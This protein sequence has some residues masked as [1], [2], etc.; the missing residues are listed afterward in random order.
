M[1]TPTSATRL[2][3]VMWST[4]GMLC[5]SR[6][7]GSKASMRRS[8]SCSMGAQSAP[9]RLP[10]LQVFVEQKAMVVTNFPA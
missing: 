8:I 5:H 6:T 10:L 2:H 1:F 3:A 4:P 7:A 9:Q